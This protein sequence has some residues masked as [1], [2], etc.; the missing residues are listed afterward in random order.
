MPDANRLAGVAGTLSVMAKIAGSF[1]VILSVVAGL[2]VVSVARLSDVNAA[3]VEVRDAWLPNVGLLGRILSAIKDCRTGSAVM[4]LVGDTPEFAASE[5]KLRKK[6]DMITALRAEYGPRIKKATPDEAAIEAFDSAWPQYLASEHR[7]LDAIH[8]GNLQAAQAE[9]L[10]A[11]RRFYGLSADPIE[12][13]LTFVGDAG[14][15]AAG[16]GDAIYHET[17]LVIAGAV[18]LAALLSLGLGSALVVGVCAPIRRLT[19]VMRRLAAGDLDEDIGAS[20]RCGLERGDE[21]GAMARAVATLKQGMVDAEA[22]RR[23]QETLKAASA[24][25]QRDAMRTTA[26]T[27]EATVGRLVE[28][29]SSGASGLES[30]AR[31]MSETAATAHDQ[32]STVGSAAEEASQSVGNVAA[33]AEQLTASIAEIARQVRQSTAMTER[34]VVDANRTNALVQALAGGADKIG[35]VVDLISNIAR[36]TNLLALNA[37]IEAARAGDAGKGFAVVATEVKS[38]A[39]Q[40]AKA[41][42]DIAAQIAQI[43]AATR[44]TVEAIGGITGT[45]ADVSA[46]AASIG[47]SVEQQGAATHEI[48]QNVQ[49]T[50]QSAH[51]VSDS[52]GGVRDASTQTG[53]AAEMVLGAASGLS[54]QAR[55]MAVEVARF[56]ADVRAA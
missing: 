16:R 13:E 7:L 5:A 3:A 28:G 27:F 42:S 24:G 56:L 22:L 19:G 32:A 35:L 40:T 38:L 17:I 15:A 48:A 44:D 8:A 33:A 14:K 43:Q 46:I 11:N 29:L 51:A 36:Q 4:V 41:T 21:I 23:E 30:T 25:L 10:G 2:G 6:L 53:Q 9:F 45:I 18:A 37:T 54:A 12:A 49:R 31:L 20:S 55:Q 34:A 1:A 52:V 47:A 39:G 26:D 50:A